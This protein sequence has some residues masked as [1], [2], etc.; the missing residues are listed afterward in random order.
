MQNPMQHIGKPKP[1]NLSHVKIS[2]ENNVA[3]VINNHY[4]NDFH[5]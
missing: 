5:G 4:K 1:K 2:M 3:T